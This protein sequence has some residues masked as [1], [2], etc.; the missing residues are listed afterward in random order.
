MARFT[1]ANVERARELIGHYPRAKSATIP[2]CHLAQEQDGWLTED[3]MEHIAEL[4]GC[5]PAEVY[6]TASFY[7]MF[8]FHPVGTYVIGV[9]TNISCMIL[10]GEEVLE[11]CERK[12]GVRTGST[13]SDGL[14]TLEEMECL[15]A[16]TR[17][18]CL[19]VNYRYVE[20][21]DEATVD[22]LV[23]D[24]RAGRRSSEFPPH[25]TLAR[26]RQSIPADRRAHRDTI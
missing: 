9:C 24:L 4:V 19:Q 12:L 2:L 5:T 3:A 14:F 23:D 25:G 15:A 1:P 21:V 26:V 11:A 7:E 6:G 18:P 16:C 22:A 13:T 20:H 8:K 17:A 10:G